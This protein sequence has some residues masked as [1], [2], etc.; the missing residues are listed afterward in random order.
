MIAISFFETFQTG[1]F[2]ESYTGLWYF[3]C[4]IYAKPKE[5]CQRAANDNFG[6][7]SN[8]YLICPFTDLWRSSVLLIQNITSIDKNVLSSFLLLQS[9][10][11][12][13]NL[14]KWCQFVDA[15]ERR[16]IANKKT[17]PFLIGFS[18]FEAR[19]SRKLLLSGFLI[20]VPKLLPFSLLIRTA[21]SENL[22]FIYI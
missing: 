3:G 9:N 10:S 5:I 20:I 2:L 13:R 12:G 21:G 17:Q 19:F 16:T 22:F 8:D 14:D 15:S 4:K 6:I 1:T 7:Y 18:F 11:N